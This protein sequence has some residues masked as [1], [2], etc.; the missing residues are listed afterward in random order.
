MDIKDNRAVHRK[1]GNYFNNINV[2]IERSYQIQD[3]WLQNVSK[4]RSM[5]GSKI[6]NWGKLNLYSFLHRLGI[7]DTLVNTGI[8]KDWFIEFRRYWRDILTGRMPLTIM[9]FHYLRVLYRSGIQD[10]QTI[11][12][13]WDTHKDHLRNWQTPENIQ[14][15]FH[16]VYKHA[17]NP[18]R[19]RRVWKYLNNGMTVLEFGCS[20]A[21]MY[22]TWMRFFNHIDLNWVLADIPNYPFHYSRHTYGQNPKVTFITIR[23]NLLNEPLQNYQGEFDTII[24]QEVYE[25]LHNPLEVTKHLLSKLKKGGTFFFD[26]AASDGLGYD[27]PASVQQRYETLVYLSENLNIIDGNFRINSETLETYIGVKI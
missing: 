21:P 6:K 10:A 18:I 19:N 17:I 25:H 24:V 14:A 15:I 8:I 22:K 26:Y 23:E 27:T 11:E 3:I 9:D 16:Y 5:K 12:L 20:L 2:D 4:K 7:Y 1:G 13:N